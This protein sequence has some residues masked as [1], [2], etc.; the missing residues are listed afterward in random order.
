MNHAESHKFTILILI[1]ILLLG[2][3]EENGRYYLSAV[4]TGR[5]RHR[6]CLDDSSLPNYEE[7]DRTEQRHLDTV[8]TN[9]KRGTY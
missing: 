7:E 1:L 3:Q 5:C 8:Q 4:C 9:R 6:H 2:D